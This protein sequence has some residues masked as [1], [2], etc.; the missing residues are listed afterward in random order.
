MFIAALIILICILVIFLV[1]FFVVRKTIKNV[2]GSINSVISSTM[3]ATTGVNNISSLKS[4]ASTVKGY[5]MEEYSREKSVKGMTNVLEDAILADFPDFNKDIIYSV[6]QSN[7][8]KIF[9]CIEN[10]S[11]ESIRYDENLSY[12]RDAL[13][14]KVEDMK[15]SN[16]YE[17]FDGL[18]FHRHA[19]SAYARKQGKATV[20]ISSTLCYYYDTNRKDKKSF[21]GVLKETRYTSE[22]VY[23]FDDEKIGKRQV[24]MGVHCP[25]CGAPLKDLL[26][27][28]CEYCSSSIE[29]VNYKI[30]KMSS[31]KEDYE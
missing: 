29:K 26:S 20:K 24:S 15:N 10:K 7:L 19:I 16:T 6:C 18:R 21:P 8:S 11:T 13:Q 28:R 17:K 2:T 25:N 30:W 31:Y 1:L 4:F 5:E 3:G 14:E 23:T 27:N 12:I 9:N 22:F